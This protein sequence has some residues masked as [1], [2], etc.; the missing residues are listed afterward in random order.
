[1]TLP[2]L[3]CFLAI[4]VF[5]ITPM[6]AQSEIE[7]QVLPYAGVQSKELKEWL[8]NFTIRYAEKNS[9]VS[10]EYPYKPAENS[11][12]FLPLYWHFGPKNTKYKEASTLYTLKANGRE[13]LAA[14]IAYNPLLKAESHCK[15]ND[16]LDPTGHCEWIAQRALTCHLF[17]FDPQSR[18]LESVTPLNITRDPRLLPGQKMRSF[19][20][21]DAKHAGD[22][23]QIEGWPHC[24]KVLAVA[25]AKIVSDALLFTLGYFDSAAPADPRSEPPEFSTTILVLVRENQGKLQVIQEDSCLGNPNMLSSI[26]VARKALSACNKADKAVDHGEAQWGDITETRAIQKNNNPAFRED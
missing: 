10:K 12:D 7:L 13:Y 24:S 23:R 6:A 17:L 4:I 18:K 20:Y 25:P 26:S 15:P 11:K 3:K 21:Y 9:L 14:V 5:L 16:S 19:W 1:M 2:S 8:D 22:P